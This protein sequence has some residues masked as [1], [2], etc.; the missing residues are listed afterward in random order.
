MNV[1]DRVDQIKGFFA[2]AAGVVT[3]LLGWTGVV[4][5]IMV[6]CMAL[7][8]LSGSAAALRNGEWSSEAAREGLWHKAGELLALLV[9]V[10]LDV[11]L[12][13]ALHSAAAPVFAE[14]KGRFFTLLVAFWYIFTELGSI[15]E[16]AAKLGAPVPEILLRGVRKLKKKVEPEEDETETEGTDPRVAAGAAPR[17]DS[18]EE[19]GGTEEDGEEDR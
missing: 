18:K 2:L 1:P 6:I 5:L 12:Y 17:N 14:W 8:Y 11:A 19:A 3:G 10:L 16:N 9:A 13:S 15:L 4:V 7:D